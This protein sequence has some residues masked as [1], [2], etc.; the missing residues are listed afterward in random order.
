MRD[1]PD[2]PGMTANTAK[3]IIVPIDGSEGALRALQVAVARRGDS[4]AALHLLNVQ[5]EIASGNVRMFISKDMIHHYCEEESL[6]AMASA[7]KMLDGERVPFVPVMRVGHPFQVIADYADPATGD[8]IVMGSRG[9]TSVGNLML[10][11]VATKVI[12]AARVPVTL[13]K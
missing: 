3:K 1:G 12:H 9:M 5:P 4:G 13:V 6:S 11:S 7:M 8:E 10:G 2:D